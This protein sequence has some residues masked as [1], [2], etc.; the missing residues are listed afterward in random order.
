VIKA[1]LRSL[2]NSAEFLVVLVVAFGMFVPGNLISVL[3]LRADPG[4][5]PPLTDPRLASLVI[6]ELAVLALLL[7]FLHL[8]GWTVERLGI[9]G[10]ARDLLVGT[11]LAIGAY[12]PY[13]AIYSVT[14]YLWPNVVS[15]AQV[16]RVVASHLSWGI[17]LA[18]CVV[19]PLFEEIFVCGYLISALEDRIGPHAAVNVSTA[20]R[21]FYHAYQGLFR[22]LGIAPFGL[23]LSYWYVRTNR[24]WP[25]IVAHT[26]TDFVGLWFSATIS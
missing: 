12:V 23:V 14:A 16:H 1:R 3:T 17:V 21:V 26:L 10:R 11:A 25:V 2:P 5:T 9:S 19:N 8:R 15:G 22:A 13:V 6:Y 24:L 20:L 18:A 4:P 7:P